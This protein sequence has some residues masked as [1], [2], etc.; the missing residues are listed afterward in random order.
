MYESYQPAEDEMSVKAASIHASVFRIDNPP[1]V[2][3]CTVDGCL[4]SLFGLGAL[5]GGEER[6]RRA[7][8]HRVL[9]ARMLFPQVLCDNAVQCRGGGQVPVKLLLHGRTLAEGAMVRL[10]P[11][12]P[13]FLAAH[14]STRR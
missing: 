8:C 7:C 5:M 10:L 14:R 3:G 13:G 6:E 12:H 9:T 2:S 1:R 4:A 11:Q